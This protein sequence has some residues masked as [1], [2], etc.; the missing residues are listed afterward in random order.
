MIESFRKSSG[1]AREFNDV[2]ERLRKFWNGSANIEID[3]NG[4]H[5]TSNAEKDVLLSTRS[6]SFEELKIREIIIRYN[7]GI[8]KSFNEEEW[9]TFGNNIMKNVPMIKVIIVWDRKK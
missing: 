5:F 3:H 8:F 4:N 6:K 1:I 9:H 7:D 2:L